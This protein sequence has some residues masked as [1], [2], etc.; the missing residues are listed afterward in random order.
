MSYKDVKDTEEY[1]GSLFTLQHV[2]AG[3]VFLCF[4]FYILYIVRGIWQM[5][6]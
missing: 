4:M 3:T 1:F 6:N 2:R 5:G